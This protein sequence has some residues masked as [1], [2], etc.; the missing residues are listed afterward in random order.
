MDTVIIWAIFGVG[1]LLLLFSI[2]N[3]SFGLKFKKEARET[4]GLVE[5]CMVNK[6]VS[7]DSDGDR[8]VETDCLVILKLN[9]PD[10]PMTVE[11]HVTGSEYRNVR[12]GENVTVYYLPHDQKHITLSR[13]HWSTQGV[14]CLLASIFMLA[15]WV[16]VK[17]FTV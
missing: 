5:H 9:E 15:I 7:Y 10:L 1:I 2:Y 12:Q 17:F 14:Y 8:K 6:R 3:I 13:T 4:Q 16:C 11:L